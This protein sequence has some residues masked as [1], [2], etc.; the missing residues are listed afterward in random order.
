[1]PKINILDKSVFNRISAG[2]VVERPFSVVKELVENAIDAHSTSIS[3]SIENGGIDLIEVKDNG[4]GIDYDD[5]EKAFLPHATSKILTAKDLDNILTLGFRG[6]ALASISAVSK[7]RIISKQR[8]GVGGSCDCIGGETTTTL[9]ITT[10]VGTIVRVTDLFYNT[11]V[12]AK[13]LKQ[14]KSEEADIS[15]IV[16]RLMLANPNISFKYMVNGRVVYQTFGDGLESAMINVY[17]YSVVN[18]CFYIETEKNGMKIKG[19][20]GKHNYVKSN[21]TYQTLIV[22]GRYVLN[23]TINSAITNAYAAYLM[24]RQ[25]PFYVLLVDLPAEFVDVNVHPNKT[26]VRFQNNQVVYGSIY[27]VISSVLDGTNTAL[28]IVKIDLNK[29]EEELKNRREEI[30]KASPNEQATIG[31]IEKFLTPYKQSSSVKKSNVKNESSSFSSFS[32]TKEQLDIFAQNKAYIEKLEKSKINQ[33]K[34]EIEDPLVYVGQVF[35]TFLIYQKADNLYIVDQHAA[36]ERLLYDKMLTY[37]EATMILQP[38]LVPIRI[39]PNPLEEKV[40]EEIISYVRNIGIE[41]ERGLDGSYTVS[42]LPL[43]LVDIDFNRFLQEMVEDYALYNKK[44]PSVILEKIM[45]KACKSAIKAGDKLSRVE[46][47]KLTAMLNE[48]FGLKCPHGRPI[49][50]KITKNEIYKWFKRIV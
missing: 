19:Y 33:E 46:I 4:D 30:R 44:L 41:M 49:A 15:N 3:I 24:K 26:E 42:V 18:N 9:P 11:P 43:E 12:R 25:Y 38:L 14:P 8:G 21:R 36:H 1:M 29:D 40:L 2:E 5:I 7:T 34:I 20:I 47:D 35:N 13:F 22:N 31:T 10:E 23:N 17:G 27:S 39:K 45:Q 16:A 28:D 48:D 32:P 6:E 50:V 37:S